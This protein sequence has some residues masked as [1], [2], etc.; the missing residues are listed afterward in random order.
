M[1]GC[2]DRRMW[3]GYGSGKGEDGK[4]R[5]VMNRNGDTEEN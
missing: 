4:E 3:T 2:R 5:V 1:S